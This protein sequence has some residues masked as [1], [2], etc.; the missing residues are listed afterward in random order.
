MRSSSPAKLGVGRMN[1]VGFIRSL[2]VRLVHRW[3]P[4]RIFVN[5][6][7]YLD[8]SGTHGSSVQ[9][10]IGGYLGHARDWDR[11]EKQWARMLKD[12]E[13]PYFHAHEAYKRTGVCKGWAKGK[14]NNLFKAAERIS[15][16][17]SLFGLTVVLPNDEYEQHYKIVGKR[18]KGT[19][20]PDSKY[21]LCFRIAMSVIGSLLEQ[22]FGKKEITLNVVLEAGGPNSGDAER[23]FHLMKGDKSLEYFRRILGTITFVEKDECFETQSADGLV[24]TAYG[25]EQMG[26]PPVRIA[27]APETAWVESKKV[28]ATQVKEGRKVSPV[29]R[30]EF[31]GEQLK[32]LQT[33]LFLKNP[34]PIFNFASEPK[35]AGN[36]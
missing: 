24:Y 31:N 1:S 16:R 8:E 9:T 5:L 22:K 14:S 28:A 20:I 3:E 2:T 23:I 35:G 10:M 19:A 6:T 29:F 25:L 11:F 21:G 32:E 4:E 18:P 17:F 30:L 15:N 12:F 27:H 26:E 33:H 13:I 34:L 7:V 36:A